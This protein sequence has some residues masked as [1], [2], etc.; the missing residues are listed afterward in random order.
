M[1]DYEIKEN[2]GALF[3]NAEGVKKS[4]T[5]PHYTG[6]TLISPDMVGKVIQCAG[7]M[8]TAKSGTVYMSL[9]YSE[10]KPKTDEAKTYTT[11]TTDDVEV[12][13]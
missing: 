5:A 4:K 9:K 6:N 13:F 3:D 7:W 12:P 1:S 10:F 8:K 2:T 11:T